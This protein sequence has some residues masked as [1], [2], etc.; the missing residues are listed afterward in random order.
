VDHSG[1]LV[2][3]NPEG[4]YAGFFRAPHDQNKIIKALDSLLN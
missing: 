2:L 4:N 1:S 3:I